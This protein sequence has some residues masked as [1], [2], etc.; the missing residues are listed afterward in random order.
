M[1]NVT[2]PVLDIAEG[3]EVKTCC[4]LDRLAVPL[5]VS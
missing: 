2:E 4:M 1:E 3:D 5:A